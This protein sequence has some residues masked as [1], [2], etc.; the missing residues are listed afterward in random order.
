[1]RYASS[2]DFLRI[3]VRNFR[4]DASST[5]PA[6]PAPG[7]LWTDTSVT[8]NKVRWFDGTNWIAAD[9]TSIPAGF[10]N[11]SH[12]SGSAGIELSKLATDPL[13]RSNHTGT[14]PSTTIS[15]FDAR[16][17]QS[18]IDQLTAP[19]GN[20]DFNGVRLLNAANPVSG[21]DVATKTYVDNARAG[22]SVKDPVRVAAQG[23]VNLAS[24]GAEMDGVALV[25]GDRF[26]APH[27]NTGTQAGIYI[28]NGPT[29]AA[30]RAPDADDSGEVLD[31][32]MLAV[33]EGTDAGRQYIQV[34]SGSGAPGTWS[35]DW[36]IFTMGG[37]TY[38]AGNGLSLSGTTFSIDAPVS[39]ENGGTGAASAAAA[40]ANLGTL[41]RW[42]GDL[43]A[44]TAGVPHTFT[45]GLGTTDIGVWFR[46]K[47]DDRVINIEWAPAS[48][49]TATVYS[50]LS[51]A[52]GAVRAVA[53]G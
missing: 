14:Q 16:V 36:I 38:L 7:Q 13:A 19:N 18:R 11:N 12:I 35:Q 22:I 10:I 1:M 42:A 41:T 51:F 9:G 39:I 27:Q 50:D 30:T 2:Q 46:T 26:L 17:R 37:Q 44:L 47:A 29:T 24:P 45:H 23:N 4:P 21:T 40:R 20:V 31:G 25:Q 28:F 15:D 53:I 8:P 34:A 43:P 33:A 3:P 5:A 52:S 48:P 32:S 49:E 6:D